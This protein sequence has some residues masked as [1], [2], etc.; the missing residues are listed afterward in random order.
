MTT[1]STMA[2]ATDYARHTDDRKRQLHSTNH[3]QMLAW[4][5]RTC[6]QMFDVGYERLIHSSFDARCHDCFTRHR[7]PGA[8]A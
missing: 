3:A 5:C 1:S 8:A 6:H 2:T 7:T 4:P